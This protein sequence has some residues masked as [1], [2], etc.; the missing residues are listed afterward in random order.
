MTM[1]MV[2]Y[3]L[4]LILLIRLLPKWFDSLWVLKAF[5]NNLKAFVVPDAWPVGLLGDNYLL[6]WPDPPI[7][8]AARIFSY[9]DI[10]VLGDWYEAA[11]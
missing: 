9:V 1:V 10:S 5:W 6:Y 11:S 7:P 4:Y 2:I 3:W 8:I